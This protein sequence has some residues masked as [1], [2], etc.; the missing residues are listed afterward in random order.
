MK[1]CPVRQIGRSLRSTRPPWDAPSERSHTGNARK[2]VTR[3]G[4]SGECHWVN[5]TVPVIDFCRKRD[6]TDILC[7]LYQLQLVCWLRLKW[8]IAQ[9]ES[10]V[11]QCPPLKCSGDCT[12]A[13]SGG[14]GFLFC[15]SRCGR[16]SS[17]RWNIPALAQ[18]DGIV[19]D[20]Q[21]VD[22]GP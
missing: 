2:S 3:Q 5:P 9:S 10:V 7:P 17:R 18:I 22:S 11:K 13:S 1:V 4:S 15:V 16:C 19:V 8:K 6:H 21:A 20:C 12:G 14:Y